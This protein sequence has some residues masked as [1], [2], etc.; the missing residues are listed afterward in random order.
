LRFLSILLIGLFCSLS[1]AWAASVQLLSSGPLLAD[2]QTES[3]VQLFVPGLDARA[4]VKVKARGGTVVSQHVDALGII[5][6]GLLPSAMTTQG[7]LSL[8]VRVRGAMKLDEQVQVPLKPPALGPFRLQIEPAQLR[9]GQQEA[10]V[11]VKVAEGGHLP[12]EERKIAL[13]ASVGSISTLRYNGGGIWTAKYTAPRNLR[14]PVSALITAVDL[15][16]PERVAGRINL[17]IRVN[18]SQTFSGPPGGRVVVM[19]GNKEYGPA[20]VSPAGTVA[21][22]MD[23][24]PGPTPVEVFTSARGQERSKSTQ[25]IQSAADVQMAFVALPSGMK[26]PVGRPVRLLMAHTDAAGAPIAAAQNIRVTGPGHPVLKDLG[27]GWYE[28]QFNTPREPGAFEVRAHLGEG[29]IAFKA[30]AVPGV[31]VLSASTNPTHLN[32]KSNLTMTV[33]VRDDQGAAL[34]GQKLG[35]FINGGTLSGR[36]RDARDG[37]YTQR[38]VVKNQDSVLLIPYSTTQQA[39]LPAAVVRVW[40]GFPSTQVANGSTVPVFVVVEDAMGL[41]VRNVDVRLMT[42]TG[43]ELPQQINTGSAGIAFADFRS[44][45]LEPGPAP[46]RAQIGALYSDTVV[47]V[48]AGQGLLQTPVRLGSPWERSGLDRWRAGMPVTQIRKAAPVVQAPL[49]QNLVAQ[50]AAVTPTAQQPA[51]VF[52]PAQSSAPSNPFGAPPTPTGSTYVDQQDVPF[53]QARVGFSNVGLRF[54][55]A[56]SDPDTSGL[57]PEAGYEKGLPSGIIGLKTHVLTR[58]V[59]DQ[60]HMELDARWGRYKLEAGEST[61]GH[62]LSNL[63]LGAK[64]RKPMELAGLPLFAEAGLWLHRAGILSF[65]YNPERTAALQVSQG[66]VGARAGLGLAGQLGGFNFGLLVAETF[67]PKPVDTHVGLSLDTTLGLLDL[68]GRPVSIRVDWAMDWKHLNLELEGVDVK[69]RDQS[70][71]LGLTAGIDL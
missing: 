27:Q 42:A 8:S 1:Q 20:L 16:A 14:K 48:L 59:D 61:K 68:G 55:Q 9:P 3:V 46:I 43:A 19:D 57:P 53:L 64:Y 29:S 62:N 51:P 28:I 15:T 49:A 17:P 63:L 44:G 22:N 67:A 39:S 12:M 56:H 35:V 13:G 66:I 37:S 52:A 40:T 41:P 2:G 25:I 70:Q 7:N 21:F 32:G 24:L 4:R 71:I 34:P 18:R 45:S 58:L 33:L 10:T 26:V 23:L 60:L 36:V 30:Q 31:P 47:W 50:Q 5:S 11:S 38:V 65:K 69:L 6:L 54:S